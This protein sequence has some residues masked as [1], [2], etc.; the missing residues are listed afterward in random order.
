[1]GDPKGAPTCLS[2]PT[3]RHGGWWDL[4]R[5]EGGKLERIE[6]QLNPWHATVR[7]HVLRKGS[8]EIAKVAGEWKTVLSDFSWITEPAAVEA[9]TTLRV[10][11]W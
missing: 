6:P 11:L 2:F 10:Q 8:L 4:V 9:C 7:Y 3:R 5:R 1:V